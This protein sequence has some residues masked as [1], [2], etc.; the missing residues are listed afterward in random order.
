MKIFFFLFAFLAVLLA[1]YPFFDASKKTEK[2]VDLPWQIEILQDGST[3]V[4]GLHLGHSRL[5]DA[6]E[7]LGNDMKL[8]IVASSGEKGKL[9]MYFGHYR[10]GLLSGK[11]VLQTNVSEQ[12]INAWRENSPRSEH[13]ETGLA[14]KY[15]V[16]ADDLPQVLDEVVV[17]LTFLPAVNLDEQVIVARFGEPKKRIHRLGV[18]HFLYPEKGL[19]LALHAESK[20]VLQYVEPEKFQQLIAP[21]ELVPLEIE[22][23]EK[24]TDKP[25]VQQTGSS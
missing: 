24:I 15:F 25:A 18:I 16:S 5:S 17:S 13:M 6:I 22:A 12:K 7:I 2:L 21:L 19:D 3:R 23:I 14:K 8:A 10:T 20:E 9:E 1:A 4:F 11:L